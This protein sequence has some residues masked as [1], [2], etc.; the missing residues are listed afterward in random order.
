MFP[1]LQS[2]LRSNLGLLDG[3]IVKNET[4]I[5][6]M[7]DMQNK[8]KVRLLISKNKDDAKGT[9]CITLNYFFADPVMNV[10][11]LLSS[12]TWRPAGREL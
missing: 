12:R 5:F 1:S 8:L 7:K 2:D 4:T 11:S 10:F 6:E 3:K 9:F